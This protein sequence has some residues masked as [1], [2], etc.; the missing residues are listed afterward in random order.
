MKGPL[1]LRPPS[2]ERSYPPPSPSED[3]V[4][5]GGGLNRSPKVVTTTVNTT[6]RFLTFKQHFL[7]AFFDKIKNDHRKWLFVA[8]K[9]VCKTNQ[10]HAI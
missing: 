10:K 7:K 2:G 9:P 1:D 5:P 8:E 4:S 6:A 3:E